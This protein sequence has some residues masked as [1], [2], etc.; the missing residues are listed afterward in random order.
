M[1]HTFTHPILD[2]LGYD[3][4]TPGNEIIPQENLRKIIDVI[5][6]N[7][8]LAWINGNKPRES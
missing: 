8:T 4:N 5:G 3:D 6:I 2:E 1:R 7:Q